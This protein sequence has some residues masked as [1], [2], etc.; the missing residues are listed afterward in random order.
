MKILALLES[1][2]LAQLLQNSSERSGHVFRWQ[3]A[4]DPCEDFG[5]YALLF[6][7]CSPD[8]DATKWMHLLEG[9]GKTV[10]PVPVVALVPR[11]STA[12]VGRLTDA[13]VSD[14]L[15]SPPSAQELDDELLSFGVSGH[16]ALDP[17]AREELDRLRLTD[18]VG[19]SPVFEACVSSLCRACTT[20]ANV[21]L[22]GSTGTGKEMFARSLHRISRRRGEP[23]CAVN[24]ATLAPALAESELFGHARGAFTG[25]E[26]RTDGWFAAASAGTL[27]LD[28]VADLDPATQVKL[29]R[30]VE[31]R[32]F[33]RVG[34]TRPIPFCARLISATSRPLDELVM[35]GLFR[36]DLFAR[37]KQIQIRLPNLA[38]RPS[39]IRPLAYHF[40]DK[41]APG[42]RMQVVE[43]AMAVLE[44]Y[45]WPKNVRE[46][47]NAIIHAIS[48]CGGVRSSIL[49]RDIPSEL[50]RPEANSAVQIDWSIRIPTDTSYER[51]RQI[52][53]AEVD[54]LYLSRYLAQY[55]GNR[56]AAARAARLDRKTFTTRLDMA[57]GDNSK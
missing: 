6:L 57:E 47:E 46:L 15:Y 7:E 25:A 30:A 48:E 16:P 19:A 52:A 44:A 51:A 10:P 49:W 2:A 3:T 56:T 29:L 34:E 42:R 17:Q 53:L 50:R 23:F 36:Q 28:E 41:H 24:C 5:Q 54:R 26:S 55:K 43:S 21:L 31:Q 8:M 35:S 1:K 9:A 33:C 14:I 12:L 40:L 38:E 27:L 18:L 37:I 39:D 11:G 20:E 22:T 4:A 13:G 45:S 32:E